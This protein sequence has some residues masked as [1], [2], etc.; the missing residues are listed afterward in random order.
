M[1]KNIIETLTG[2]VVLVVAGSFLAFAYNGSQVNVSGGYV[3]KA[4]FTSAAGIALGSDVRVGGIK[5]GVVSDLGLDEK[6]YEAVVSMQL[7]NETKLPKDSSAA[8]VGN[9]LLGEK[10][11][12]LVPGNDDKMLSSGGKIQFTQSAV[13]LEEMIG[14]FMFSGGGVDKKDTKTAAAPA[15]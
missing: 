13:N 12:Q 7:K 3:V 8:I 15:Q 11:V 14:K 6:T 1:Q 4:N 10:Y 2:A 9:G 5:V